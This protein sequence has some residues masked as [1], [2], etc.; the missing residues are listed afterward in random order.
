MGDVRC[1][2]GERLE[3]LLLGA[4]AA[5]HS[6]VLWDVASS[7]S[8]TAALE[9][10]VLARRPHSRAF[11]AS[12]ASP[13]AFV[14]RDMDAARGIVA[15]RAHQEG[16]GTGDAAAPH[17]WMLFV[18]RRGQARS[19]AAAAQFAHAGALPAN[20]TVGYIRGGWEALYNVWP[21]LQS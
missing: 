20:V 1:V 4:D 8:D 13:S 5:R 10:L 21:Q 2:S 17:V 6:V 7:G 15:A 12:S 19:P 14:Q 16:S 9:R 3:E 11:L 18:C